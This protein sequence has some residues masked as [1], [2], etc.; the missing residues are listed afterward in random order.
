M[1]LV[2]KH[3]KISIYCIVLFIQVH[4]YCYSLCSEEQNPS[5]SELTVKYPVDPITKYF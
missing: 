1:H 2:T 4:N 5:E 3:F